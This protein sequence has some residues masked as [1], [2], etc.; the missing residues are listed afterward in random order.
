M[1]A[2]RGDV[3]S[4]S[5]EFAF[6]AAGVGAPL[7]G[8]GS[9]HISCPPGGM[10][11]VPWNKQMWPRTAHFYPQLK[12]QRLLPSLASTKKSRW[13]S[14]GSKSAEKSSCVLLSNSEG[15]LYTRHQVFSLKIYLPVYLSLECQQHCGFLHSCRHR[16]LILRRLAFVATRNRVSLS[17]IPV[18][19]TKKKKNLY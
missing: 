6:L 9:E 15:I 8:W 10:H 19:G 16:K 17:Y 11:I 13:P 14:H 2:S 5:W 7:T 1:P 12:K 3:Q 4:L 18:V